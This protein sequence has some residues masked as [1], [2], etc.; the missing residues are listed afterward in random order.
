MDLLLMQ[1]R[2]LLI[3]KSTRDWTLDGDKNTRFY[4]SFV[5]GRQRRNKIGI[6]INDDGVL[7]DDQLELGRMATRFFK[8][9]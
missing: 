3:Q 1:E 8:E 4:H 9:A 7:I 6:L 2:A 5:K